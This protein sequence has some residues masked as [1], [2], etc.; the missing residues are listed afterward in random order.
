[1]PST[2]PFPYPTLFRSRGN[3]PPGRSSPKRKDFDRKRERA[4]RTSL[5]QAAAEA[6]AGHRAELPHG[7]CG[8]RGAD[9]LLKRRAPC[10]LTFSRSEEHTSELQSQSKL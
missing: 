1:R 5:H 2:T 8:L 3:S 6:R 10:A 7:G 9:R 4:R